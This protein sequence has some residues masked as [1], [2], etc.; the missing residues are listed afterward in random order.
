MYPV[1]ITSGIFITTLLF[2]NIFFP[3]LPIL[4][5]FLIKDIGKRGK[6]SLEKFLQFF[7]YK[8]KPKNKATKI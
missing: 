5:M 3:L 1:V 4:I 8:D 7:S 6:E 2:E